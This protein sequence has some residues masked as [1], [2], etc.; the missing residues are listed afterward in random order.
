[1][2]LVVMLEPVIWFRVVRLLEQKFLRSRFPKS[3]I[4]AGKGV[5]GGNKQ[6]QFVLSWDPWV[7][8]FRI[9]EDF[10]SRQPSLAFL[11]L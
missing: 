9:L 6:G 7:D 3:P 8:R 1:M 11:S 5:R 2:F 10:S 4:Y